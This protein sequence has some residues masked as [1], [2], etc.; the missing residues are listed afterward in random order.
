MTSYGLHIWLVCLAVCL[1]AP[2]LEICKEH[3]RRRKARLEQM[4]LDARSQREQASFYQAMARQ[5]RAYYLQ[6]E[7]LAAHG[8]AVA[9]HRAGEIAL[10]QQPGSLDEDCAEI[11]DVGTAAAWSR[12]CFASFLPLLFKESFSLAPCFDLFCVFKSF[13]TTVVPVFLTECRG[14]HLLTRWRTLTC[15]I[16]GPSSPTCWRSA[17]RRR[18]PCPPSRRRPKRRCERP[19]EG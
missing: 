19:N 13:K 7:R 4:A 12:N 5:Q 16:A 8:K 15:A 18:A 2:R 17:R 10:V 6:S 11:F 14:K 1:G 3:L 9:R